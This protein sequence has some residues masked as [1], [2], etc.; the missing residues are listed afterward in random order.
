MGVS[1]PSMWSNPS[2]IRRPC[3]SWWA[4]GCGDESSDGFASAAREVQHVFCVLRMRGDRTSPVCDDDLWPPLRRSTDGVV[5]R[6]ARWPLLRNRQPHH[7][8]HAVEEAH[9]LVDLSAEGTLVGNEVVP[10]LDHHDPTDLGPA[11]S[12]DVDTLR[13]PAA[14]DGVEGHRPPDQGGGNGRCGSEKRGVA[15]DEDAVVVTRGTRRRPDG[16]GGGRRR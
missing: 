13:E 6:N 12:Q 10:R 3:I 15:E 7:S 11:C 14:S 1:C 8:L 4:D 9:R 16:S 2:L 5:D